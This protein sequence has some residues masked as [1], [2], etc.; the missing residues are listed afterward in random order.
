MADLGIGLPLSQKG[1]EPGEAMLL[2]PEESIPPD[3]FAGLPH[4]RGAIVG[5]KEIQDLTA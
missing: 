2:E 4:Q 1:G 5:L 3:G